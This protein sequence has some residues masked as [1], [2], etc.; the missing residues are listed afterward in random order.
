MKHFLKSTLFFLFGLSLVVLSFRAHSQSKADKAFN[1]ELNK[2]RN[3][4]TDSGFQQAIIMLDTLNAVACFQK[5]YARL[6]DIQTL[7]GD[8]YLQQK[9]EK[10]ALFHYSQA[11]EF[12]KKTKDPF[13][14][15]EVAFR[16]GDVFY[17]HKLY[18]P[19]YKYF[20]LG[21]SLLFWANKSQYRKKLNSRL[22][23]TSYHLKMYNDSRYYY[24]EL[25]KYSIQYQN[26]DYE[27]EAR[28]GIA[29]SYVKLKEYQSAIDY[30]LSL[31]SIYK[32]LQ[33]PTKKHSVYFQVANYYIA[34][35]ELH[36]AI[37]YCHLILNDRPRDASLKMQTLLLL[38]WLQIENGN[39][40]E[41]QFKNNLKQAKV[42]ATKLKQD[43]S[44]IET[45]YLLTLY[46]VKYK[47]KKESK[48]LL[49]HLVSMLN[50]KT[51]YDLQSKIYQLGID[52]YKQ[53]KDYKKLS[54]FYE[55]YLVQ[56]NKCNQAAQQK[57][58]NQ[59]WKSNMNQELTEKLDSAIQLGLYK[60]FECI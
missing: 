15:L 45:E 5:Q 51:D 18:L 8:I 47:K 44:V 50:D 36:K 35:N 55:R 30:K 56:Q 49:D 17:T 38:A 59:R 57:K 60:A 48:K 13:L 34:I 54:A 42:I 24:S 53:Q 16:I 21:D 26:L 9:D 43:D 1:K 19:A 20:K 10:K 25:M 6:S 46:S 39:T 27:I 14:Q 3:T 33:Q 12:S 32:R 40:S 31:I 52:F 7:I 22:A 41:I 37:D 4:V 2:A 23:N 29:N 28:N 11:F 58:T